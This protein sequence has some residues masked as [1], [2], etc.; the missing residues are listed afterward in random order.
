MEPL[1]RPDM[2]CAVTAVSVLVCAEPDWSG[3]F[4]PGTEVQRCIR[5]VVD[6]HSLGGRLKLNAEVQS[7]VFTGSCRRVTTSDGTALEAD[8]LI[9]ATGCSI[10]P[11]TPDTPGLESFA[12]GVDRRCRWCPRFNPGPHA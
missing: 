1:P 6:S 11:F 7:A 8:F 2:R 3:L 9:S 10:T 5:D 4:A 12:G